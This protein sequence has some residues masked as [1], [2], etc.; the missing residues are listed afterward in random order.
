MQPRI[1]SRKYAQQPLQSMLTLEKY[2]AESGLEPKLLHLVRMR[3]SD[4]SADAH[5]ADACS[6]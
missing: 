5:F 6:R 4:R 1:D 3:A 2:I